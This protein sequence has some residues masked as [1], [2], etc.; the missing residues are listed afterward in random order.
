MQ[1]IKANSVKLMHPHTVLESQYLPDT[2][3]LMNKKSK[4]VQEKRAQNTYLLIEQPAALIPFN[5]LQLASKAG[6]ELLVVKLPGPGPLE[7]Q[8]ASHRLSSAPRTRATLIQ[9]RP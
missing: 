2:S 6:Q 9:P 5:Y 3:F 4:K 7:E 1:S 8:R